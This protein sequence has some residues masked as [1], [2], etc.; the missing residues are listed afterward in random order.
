MGFGNCKH[1]WMNVV[2]LMGTGTRAMCIVDDEDD[3][4]DDGTE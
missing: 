3:D 1:V 2:A 4:G